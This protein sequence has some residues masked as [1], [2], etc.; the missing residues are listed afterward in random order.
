MAITKAAWLTRAAG[1]ALQGSEIRTVF[2]TYDKAGML[3]V[4]G[5]KLHLL[6][7]QLE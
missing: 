5:G 2:V 6:A 1:F 3:E 7:C 4:T